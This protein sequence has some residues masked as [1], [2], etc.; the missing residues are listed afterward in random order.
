MKQVMMFAAIVVVTLAV[1]ANPTQLFNCVSASKEDRTLSG[2]D[3]D[4]ARRSNCNVLRRVSKSA[5][6]AAGAGYA[7][8]YN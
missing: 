1:H 2:S 6:P 3:N 5:R 7:Q 8:G 4:A